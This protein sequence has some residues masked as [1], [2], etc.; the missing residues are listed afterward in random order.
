MTIIESKAIIAFM[1]FLSF[2][3]ELR[4]S[5]KIIEKKKIK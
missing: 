3:T 5:L 2:W 1:E 4:V